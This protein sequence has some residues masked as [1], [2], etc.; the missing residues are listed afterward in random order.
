MTKFIKWLSTHNSAAFLIV[1][2]YYALVILPHEWVG[3]NVNA[4]FKSMPR[5]S[6]DLIVLTISLV[7][8]FFVLGVFSKELIR[9]PERKKL[10]LYFGL[11]LLLIFLVNSYLFVINIESV[12]Y[13]QYAVGAI[14]L[15]GLI[16]HY[17]VV[18]F[19]ATL[20]AI[21]DEG[22]QYFYLSPHR[23]DYFDINDIITDF[24]GAAFGL[25]LLKTLSVEGWG[26]ESKKMQR[27]FWIPLV[28]ALVSFIVLLQTKLLSVYPS[29]E[30][31]MLVRKVQE[32]F[33]TTV[34]PNVT[35]H[36]VAPVEGAIIICGLFVTYYFCFRR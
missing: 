24:L 4:L 23:T 22:Y 7:G 2:I 36:V 1:V 32:G 10:L 19:V 11:T 20:I 21:L 28:L 3:V 27:G 14:L 26:S 35:F 17:Y 25:L 9:H 31:F 15:F 34:H 18:L 8:L 6:Y 30:K 12:H 33:W 5:T 16:G 29:N 13:L